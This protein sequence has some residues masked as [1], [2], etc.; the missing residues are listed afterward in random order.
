MLSP[1]PGGNTVDWILEDIFLINVRI[2]CSAGRN[3]AA[4][5]RTYAQMKCTGLIFLAILLLLCGTGSVSAAW[6]G[7]VNS[8]WYAD[9]IT[10]GHN[11][12][13][14]NP[15]LVHDEKSLA[16]LANQTNRNTSQNGFSNKY[17]LLT[18]DLDLNGN[19]PQWSQIGNKTAFKFKGSFNGGG[20]IITN[21]NITYASTPEYYRLG[22]FGYA[23]GATIRD[24]HLT[25]VVVGIKCTGEIVCAGELV[26]E[27][28][29]STKIINCSVTGT[30]TAE[31]AKASYAGGLVA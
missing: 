4:A 27:S 21:M 14:Q 2:W 12:T 10:A 19:T 31:G 22:L 20:H 13:I 9:E 17:I 5:E 23:E 15:Y 29:G 8:S 26:G 24:V 30:M 28:L 18:A 1:K 16:V 3:L 7:T 25:D 6:D 11:G